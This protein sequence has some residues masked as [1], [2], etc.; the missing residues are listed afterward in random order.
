M[1]IK[2]WESAGSNAQREL[3]EKFEDMIQDE[4]EL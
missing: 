3:R 4:L 1:P 2:R